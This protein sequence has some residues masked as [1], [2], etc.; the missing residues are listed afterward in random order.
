MKPAIL[1]CLFVLSACG[2][3]SG[4]TGGGDQNLPQEQTPTQ[5]TSDTSADQA[6]T[7]TQS[8]NGE[9]VSRTYQL[10]YPE[11]PSENS[12]PVVFF[13]HGAGGSRTDWLEQNPSIA[14]LIDA[15]EFI[16]VFPQGYQ[17]RW[18]VNSE[19]NADDVE[20][21]SLIINSLDPAGL[22]DLTRVYGIGISNGAGLVNKIAKETTIFSAIAPLIS[23]QTATLGEVVA[24][25]AVSVLQV[26]GADDSQVPVNGGPGVADSLFMSAQNSAENWASNANCNMT[27]SNR[28]EIWGDY[29]VDKITFSGCLENT[30]IDY[31]IARDSG[32]SIAFG[33][34]FNLYNAIWS[35]F[36]STENSAPQNFK[37]L[38]LGDSYTI[39]QSV[40]DACSFPMQLKNRLE[41]AFSEQNGFEQI[42]FEQNS[43]EVQIIAQTG[44]TTSIL[45]N[46]LSSEMPA[47]DFDL[48]TLLIGVNNQFQ[49]RPFSLYETDFVELVNA[50]TATVGGDANKLIIISIPDYAYTRFGQGGNPEKISA[51]LQ[52]YNDFAQQYSEDNGLS[53]LY[54]TDITQQGLDNPALVADDGLHPSQLA[55]SQFVER[56]LPLAIEKLR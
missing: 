5:P 4:N 38:A 24:P 13:F 11:N 29:T 31:V 23:Q 2:G 47:E 56:L 37:L 53:Y 12:Y 32:H 25:R 10:R 44:W 42:S 27:P 20:F 7:I 6:E 16:G 22:F 28:V 39:G 51:E 8:I 45:K 52:L 14:N 41:L 46:E 49:D 17:Q 54:I 1:I 15:G 9:L 48:V 18:N 33:D 36:Q 55:Y 40:C 26:S 3:G 19:T 35:F 34:D 30:K 21:V 50:A 43:I